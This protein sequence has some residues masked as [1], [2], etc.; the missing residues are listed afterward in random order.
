MKSRNNNLKQEIHHRTTSS[1]TNN[2]PLSKRRLKTKPVL[3]LITILFLGNI[4]WFSLWL[5]NLNGGNGGDETVATVDGETITRQEWISAMENLYGKETLQSIVNEK[6]MEKAAE[7]Y[8]IKV[9]EEEINLELSLI[10]SAQDGTTQSLELLKEQDLR[11]RIKEQLIFEKVLTKDI[12]IE[13]TKISEYYEK[14]GNLFNIP[15]TY[16]TS[17]IVVKTLEEAETV[18]QELKNG[19]EFAALA[20]EKSTDIVSASLGGT[21]GYITST[22]TNID[23]AILGVVQALNKGEMSEPFTLKDGQYAIV[24]VSEINESKSFTYEE[25]KDYIKRELALD[26]LPSTVT[27][28]SFWSEFNARSFFE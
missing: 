10:R 17:I 19:S 11:Q 24:H 14:N 1:L 21:I 26:Q 8:D 2:T 5:L 7:K 12:L 27:P 25:V 28:E 9:S 20:R 18:K 3:M 16:R 22:Q 4:L 23:P 15:T 13:E 6:V